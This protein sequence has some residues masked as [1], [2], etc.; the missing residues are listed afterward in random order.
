[1]DNAPPLTPPIPQ[2]TLV[3]CTT[4]RRA[5]ALP[6]GEERPG[7]ALLR[8]LDQGAL[9]P[10]L[11]L[12]AVECLSVCQNGCAVALT[13]PGKWSYVYGGLDPATHAADI[14]QGAALYAAAPDGLVPWRERPEVFR[15]QSV[16]RIP[17]MEPLA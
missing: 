8:A 14:L 1:M 4:C 6:E 12:R 13:A 3:V 10:G 17:P 7:A 2:A 11:T 16:A 5:G 15:K 9:P